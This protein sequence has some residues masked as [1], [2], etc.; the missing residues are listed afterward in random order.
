M[1][2]SPLL[3]EQVNSLP[4]EPEALYSEQAGQ[5]VLGSSG[6]GPGERVAWTTQNRSSLRDG[7]INTG[8]RVRT[9]KMRGREVWPHSIPGPF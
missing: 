1:K 5:Q 2:S 4:R 7:T 6:H 8:L 3:Q 9:T